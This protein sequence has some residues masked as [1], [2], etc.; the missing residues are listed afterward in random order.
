MGLVNGMGNLEE[1]VHLSFRGTGWVVSL[2]DA[3]WT[4]SGWDH[5]YGK[6]SGVRSTINL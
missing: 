3:K 1:C 5:T 6:S 4:P 2:E